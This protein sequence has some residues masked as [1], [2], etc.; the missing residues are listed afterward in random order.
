MPNFQ[1]GSGVRVSYPQPDIRVPQPAPREVVKP[2]LVQTEPDHNDFFCKE[3]G[4]A[5]EGKL[6]VEKGKFVFA[7]PVQEALISASIAAI[8]RQYRFAH[9]L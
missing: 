1:S 2:I 8:R 9:E 4:L 5:D 6:A 3:D 7:N